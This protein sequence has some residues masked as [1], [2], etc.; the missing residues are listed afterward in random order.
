VPPT[1]PARLRPRAAVL[2][3]GPRRRILSAQLL[4]VPAPALHA[5][6]LP[7]ILHT[8]STLSSTLVAHQK[9]AWTLLRSPVFLS[10]PPPWSSSSSAILPDRRHW[11][12]AS[13]E[14]RLSL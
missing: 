14:R 10:C 9:P 3:G 8:S 12:L 7:R 6:Q 11:T 4:I 5:M 2:F 13:C 1:A